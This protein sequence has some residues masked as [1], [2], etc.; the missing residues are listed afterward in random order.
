[1][2][3]SVTIAKF[4]TESFDPEECETMK[5]VLNGEQLQCSTRAHLRE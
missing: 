3:D 2:Q 4:I 5:A 1:M